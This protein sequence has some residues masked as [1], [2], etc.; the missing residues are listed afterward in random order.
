MHIVQNYHNIFGISAN[1]DLLALLEVCLFIGPMPLS[2][3]ERT[4]PEQVTDL[5]FYLKSFL[6]SNC[7]GSHFRLF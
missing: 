2:E 7:I 4:L 3:Q 5:C 1:L 6:K